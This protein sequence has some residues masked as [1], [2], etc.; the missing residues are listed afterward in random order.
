LH[1]EADDAS[2][3][4][5]LEEQGSMTRKQIA[6]STHDDGA[7]ATA[8][9]MTLGPPGYARRAGIVTA[10]ASACLLLAGGQPGAQTRRPPAIV[11][12]CA[13]CH[14]A[15]GDS[16][17]V[18]QPNLAGQKSIYLRTQLLAFRT[19]KRKHP[20]MKTIARDLTDREI[21]QLVVYYSTL[22]PR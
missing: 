18:E 2:V 10:A 12:V 13:P 16:G 6:I 4:V 19:G 9:R 8:E 1:A 20:D 14:G 22:P 15:G 5:P 3:R 7:V 21:D 17:N 11:A